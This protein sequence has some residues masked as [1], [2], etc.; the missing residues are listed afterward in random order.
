MNSAPLKIA[1][2]SRRA[3]D[4]AV[5]KWHYSRSLSSARNAYLGVWEADKF[6][7]AIVFG[8]G[9]GNA[10]NGLRFGLKRNCAV[11]ELTR[12]ALGKHSTRV[13]RILSIALRMLQR[14]CPGS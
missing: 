12:V 10:T 4:C 2:C 6:V 11:A 7:G 9:A 14:H 13:S 5:Q 1:W 8:I 3:A